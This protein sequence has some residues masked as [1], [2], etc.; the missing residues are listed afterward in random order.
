MLEIRVSIQSVPG[1]KVNIVGD[2]S[3]GH[4]NKDKFI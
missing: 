2:H 3:S 4:T 1:G